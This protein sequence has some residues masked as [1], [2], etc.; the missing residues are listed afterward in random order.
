M[1]HLKINDINNMDEGTINSKVR[2]SRVAL[3]HLRMKRRTTGIEKPH[4]IGILRKNIA[5]LLTVKNMKKNK[6]N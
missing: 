4:E 3:F 2:D 1:E 6:E 5:R